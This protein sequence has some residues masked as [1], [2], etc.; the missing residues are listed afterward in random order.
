L[1]VLVAVASDCD[2]NGEWIVS[3]ATLQ[4]R[5]RLTNRRVRQI[6]TDLVASGELAVTS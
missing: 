4:S 6:L 5:V 3:Q 2:P 1:L